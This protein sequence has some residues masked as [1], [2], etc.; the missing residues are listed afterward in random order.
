MPLVKPCH[1]YWKKDGGSPFLVDYRKFNSLTKKDAYPLR[2][3]DDTLDCLGGAF[4]FSVLDF[5]SGYFQI[6][7]AEDSKQ[8]TA[9]TTLEG[10]FEF[11]VMPFGLMNTPSTFQRLMDTVLHGLQWKICLVYIDDIIFSPTFEQHFK[12][13]ATGLKLKP[14]K[15]RF[16]CHTVP[17][18]GFLATPSGIQ[19]DPK[20]VEAVRT[21]PVPQTLTQ[22][23]VFLRLANYY[24]SFI[25]GFAW[26]AQPLTALTRNNTPFAWSQQCQEAFDSLKIAFTTAP[27]L[28]YPDFSLGFLYTEASSHSLGQFWLKFKMVVKL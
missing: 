16:G 23:R 13:L 17:Y 19:P 20:K 22:L 5:C 15:C 9:F 7:L 10:L 18:L 3:T 28:A 2:W 4:Y 6:P 25:S 14:S 11:N 27:V 1:H 24:G 26:V 21:Y 12:H 8:Y